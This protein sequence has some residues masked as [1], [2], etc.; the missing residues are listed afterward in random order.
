M[1]KVAKRCYQ[2]VSI[3][4]ALLVFVEL[5]R[6]YYQFEINIVLEQVER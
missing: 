5:L 4:H 3:W 6:L 1:P 2:V